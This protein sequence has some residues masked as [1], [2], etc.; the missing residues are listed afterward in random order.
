MRQIHRRLAVNREHATSHRR[1]AVAI[2]ALGA[3]ALGSLLSTG[4]GAATACVPGPDDRPEILQGAATA[5]ER[6]APGG[7]QGA[8]CGA[9]LVGANELYDRGS[10]G[11]TAII[12]NCVYSSMRDPSDLNAPTTGTAVIDNSVPS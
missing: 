2:A 8:W 11:N 4:A 6:N 5:A 12:K 7:Y 10:Y 3:A 9:R 1:L